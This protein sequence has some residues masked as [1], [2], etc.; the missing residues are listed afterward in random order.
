[1]KQY[2]SIFLIDRA[3]CLCRYEKLD[4]LQTARKNIRV[5]E[6]GRPH[7]VCTHDAGRNSPMHLDGPHLPGSPES[8]RVTGNR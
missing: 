4:R 7:P 8:Q 1:M 6:P 5:G 2:Y 3:G